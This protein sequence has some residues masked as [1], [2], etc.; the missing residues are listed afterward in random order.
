ML[1]ALTLAG[2]WLIY[3]GAKDKEEP[4]IVGGLFAAIIGGI[5]LCFVAYGGI[6]G[7]LI[8]EYYAINEIMRLLGK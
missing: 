1:L 8:P 4:L 7:V 5:L 2:V 6:M 3:K